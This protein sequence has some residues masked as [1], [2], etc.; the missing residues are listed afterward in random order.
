MSPPSHSLP[1]NIR[2]PPRPHP[3]LVHAPGVDVDAVAGGKDR[4]GVAVLVSGVVCDG[5]L[6]R[7]DEVRGE[8]GVGVRWVVFCKCQLGLRDGRRGGGVRT[9]VGSVGPGEDVGEAP[10]ADLGLGVGG[11]GGGVGCCVAHSFLGGQGDLCSRGFTR[12]EAVDEVTGAI[13]GGVR[14]A[15]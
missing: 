14:S 5:E 7:E 4:L 2:I 10:G 1:N 6:A 12:G 15:R 3:D 9:S 13:I 8:G 11:H